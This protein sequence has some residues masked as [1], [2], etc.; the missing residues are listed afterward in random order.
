MEWPQ[1]IHLSVAWDLH[2]ERPVFCLKIR[3]EER[4]EERDTSHACRYSFVCVLLHR[5]SS[6]WET[7]HEDKVWLVQYARL[8]TPISRHTHYFFILTLCFSHW[9]SNLRICC[10]LKRHPLTLTFSIWPHAS[11]VWQCTRIFKILFATRKKKTAILNFFSF[12]I[13]SESFQS[14]GSEIKTSI[15]NE[16]SVFLLVANCCQICD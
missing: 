3:E 5:F 9:I 16:I 13:Q 4:I 11:C 14:N 7:D 6:K 10:E 8:F 2:C 1:I 12:L 15:T